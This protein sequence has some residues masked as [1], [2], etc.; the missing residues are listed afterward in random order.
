M[1]KAWENPVKNLILDAIL[2]P[3]FFVGF[4][5]LLL[6]AII[7]CNFKEKYWTKLEKMTKKTSFQANFGLFALILGPPIFFFS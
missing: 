7:V 1:N 2:A 5:P 6:Q 4:N 3:N